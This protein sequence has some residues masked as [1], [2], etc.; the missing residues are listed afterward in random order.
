MSFLLSCCSFLLHDIITAGTWH[1]IPI[2]KVT[3]SISRCLYF[4]WK[5]V[6]SII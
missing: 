3:E 2:W 6:I 1:L 5:D 4:N